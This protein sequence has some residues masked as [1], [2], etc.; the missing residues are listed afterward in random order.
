MQYLLQEKGS[1]FAY[2]YDA[3]GKS[4]ETACEGHCAHVGDIIK[5]ISKTLSPGSK[6]LDMGCGTGYPVASHFAGLGHHVTAVDFSQAMVDTAR[7]NVPSSN[8]E[9]IKADISSFIPSSAG[10]YDVVIASHSLYNFPLGVI[11]TLILRFAR[12]V[13]RDGIFLLVFETAAPETNRWARHLSGA[14]MEF[15]FDGMTY[16][17]ADAWRTLVQEVGLTILEEDERLCL[18]KGV[19]SALAEG[20][21][22]SI[23]L[24]TRK[25]VDDP[26]LGP[27][28][29]PKELP[30][31]RKI[32]RENMQAWLEIVKRM[33]WENI[34][35][36]LVS[37]E[38]RKP[39]L[40]VRSPISA[41]KFRYSIGIILIIRRSHIRTY[42]FST[43]FASV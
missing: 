24:I 21:T 40:L 34:R 8:T 38:N 16:G 35:D 41:Y 18:P 1:E 6:I 4:Y 22:P 29:T 32:T 11:R 31:S 43:S 23:G 33:N 20:F 3:I 27:Y 15:K 19:K 28:P 9:F 14:F 12:W 7:S 26:L 30:K 42:R 13:R 17:S 5:K 39:K 25:I 37:R 10:D 2:I 36:A